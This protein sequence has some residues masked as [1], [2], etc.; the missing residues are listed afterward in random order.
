ML[1]I[2]GGLVSAGSFRAIIVGRDGSPR[3]VFLQLLSTSRRTTIKAIP[4][5]PAQ[6]PV[7][8]TNNEIELDRTPHYEPRA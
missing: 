6:S 3:G 7:P 2:P 5:P 1:M 8:G 4:S